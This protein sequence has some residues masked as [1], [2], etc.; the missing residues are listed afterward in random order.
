MKM[1]EYVV[2]VDLTQGIIVHKDVEPIPGTLGGHEW[3]HE[4]SA[5]D[6]MHSCFDNSNVLD[7]ICEWAIL[8]EEQI[9]N[10]DDKFG[11]YGWEK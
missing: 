7:A 5:D 2:S 11:V 6:F 3:D 8:D 4:V 10:L 1:N 9:Q